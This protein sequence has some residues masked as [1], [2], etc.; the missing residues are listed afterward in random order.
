MT[1]SE[2][3]APSTILARL[4]TDES[5]A[6]RV[7]AVLGE[8]LDADAAAVA[9]LEESAGAWAVEVSF[10][11]SPDEAAVRDLVAG[12]IGEAAAH[13]LTFARVAPRDWVKAS[14]EGL[15]P[16]SAGRFVVHG[17]HDRAR[18]APNRLGIEIEAALAFGT[19]HH[20]TTR[21]CLIALDTFLKRRRRV[22]LE[23]KRDDR[24]PK[25]AVARAHVL[26]LGTGSGV[27]AIA[28]A[29]ALRGSVVASDIDRIAVAAARNNARQNGVAS[30]TAV[31]HAAGVAAHPIRARAPYRLV[32][33]NILLAPLQRLARPMAD[34]VAPGA[35]IVLSGLLAPQT[36][37]A[38]SAY[39]LQGFALERRITLD[40][41][42]TLVMVRAVSRRR[43]GRGRRLAS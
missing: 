24:L 38:L 34:V 14:L 1:D 20:A 29:K 43:A 13:A 33:A 28:A 39:R 5:T 41:W 9:L 12:D 32:F 6:R 7:A 16:V 18:I 27:L 4:A 2:S 15:K 42:T 23:A 30:L 8:T 11:H 21:G 40:N 3:P 37:A 25:R 26:D 35:R 10:S 19:G 36:N 22:P 17:E 31:V